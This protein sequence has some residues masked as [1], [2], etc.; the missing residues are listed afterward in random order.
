ME[1]E[2]SYYQLLNIDILQSKVYG[3]LRRILGSI[4]L[5]FSLLSAD[6]L[7]SLISF[8]K[9]DLRQTLEHLHSILKVPEEPAPPPPL[10]FVTSFSIVIGALIGSSR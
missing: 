5:L 2:G 10:H 9:E 7:A 6:S 4:V 8:S 3:M 1:I